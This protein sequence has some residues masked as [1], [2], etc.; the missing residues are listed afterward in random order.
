MITNG[1]GSSR[2]ASSIPAPGTS[3]AIASS[4]GSWVIPANKRPGSH[5]Q[6]RYRR[7][8]ADAAEATGAASEATGATSTA[9]EGR[10][11]VTVRAPLSGPLLFPSS[12]SRTDPAD[13]PPA[14]PRVTGRGPRSRIRTDPTVDRQP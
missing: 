10:N 14:A 8:V 5:H 2:P 11:L 4:A 9:G 13:S 12:L 6:R 7:R 3:Q 1:T